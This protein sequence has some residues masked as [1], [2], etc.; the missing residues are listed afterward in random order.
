MKQVLGDATGVM[1]HVRYEVGQDQRRQSIGPTRLAMLRHEYSLSSR[2]CSA[3]THKLQLQTCHNLYS[4]VCVCAFVVCVI[5]V[6]LCVHINLCVKI[7][8]PIYVHIIHFK[9]INKRLDHIITFDFYISVIN[10]FTIIVT[11]QP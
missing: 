7:F 3:Q 10:K 4:T 5:A 6:V 2:P 1:V 8:S 11:E 9:D